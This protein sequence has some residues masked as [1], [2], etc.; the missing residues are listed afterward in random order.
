MVERSELE[1]RLCATTVT[2]VDYLP[3]RSLSESKTRGAIRRLLSLFEVTAVNRVVLTAAVECS[4]R[5]FEDAV[6]THSA[7]YSSAEQIV[8][9]NTPDFTDS[10]ITAIDPSEFLAQSQDQIR[11]PDDSG[12]G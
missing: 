3:G 9:R 5:D 1:G 10:P 11:E 12:N 7:S 2:S 6:L 4:M 8:T